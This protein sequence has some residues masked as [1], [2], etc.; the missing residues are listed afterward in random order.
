MLSQVNYMSNTRKVVTF[1]LIT[2]ASI[3]IRVSHIERT[4]NGNYAWTLATNEG[5]PKI[6]KYLN[7]EMIVAVTYSF[8]S[9]HW[10]DH[11]TGQECDEKAHRTP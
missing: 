3:S 4:P 11:L 9:T 6:I 7:P 2:G 10:D 8:C 1:H 5:Y